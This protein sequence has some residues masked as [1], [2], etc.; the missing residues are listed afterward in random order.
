M[1]WDARVRALDPIDPIRLLGI[2]RLAAGIPLEAP[3][4]VEDWGYRHVPCDAAAAV[5]V[6]WDDGEGDESLTLDIQ[7][8]G[9]PD[10]IEVV[11]RIVFNVMHELAIDGI[12]SEWYDP[13]LRP[14][15]TARPPMR[16]E[17]T[18]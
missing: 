8:D 3:I 6:S 9:S 11:E 10:M 7:R 18:E 12:A 15:W 1:S 13:Q 5:G 16:E 4:R 14:T 17:V 2:G